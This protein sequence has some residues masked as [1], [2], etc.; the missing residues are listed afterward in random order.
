MDMLEDQCL[1]VPQY[2]KGYELGGSSRKLCIGIFNILKLHKPD[3][4]IVPEF[5]IITIQILLYRFFLKKKFKIVSICDD[6][7]DMIVN[8]NNFTKI[9]EF[10][11]KIITPLLD[12]LIVV[13]PKVKDWYQQNSKKELVPYYTRRKHS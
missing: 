4:V 2:L 11:R 3:I 6:S 13:E 12:D 8:K 1:F 9:H 7:Y 5:Q 10:A